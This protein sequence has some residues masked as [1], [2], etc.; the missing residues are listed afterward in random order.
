MKEAIG[1]SFIFNLILI[2]VALFIAFFVGSISYSK[3]FKVKNAIIDIVEKH[4]NYSTEAVK[5]I[6][7]T[8]KQIGYRVN[9]NGVQSCKASGGGTILNATGTNYRYCIEYHNTPKGYYYSVTAYMYFEIPLIGQ[10]LEFP[11]YGETRMFLDF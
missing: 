4:E 3:A 6:D 8:L 9:K 10:M 1:N 5:E 11:V 7:E 2:F